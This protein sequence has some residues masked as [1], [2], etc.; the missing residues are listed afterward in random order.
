[1]KHQRNVIRE[2]FIARIKRPLQ[3]FDE[4]SVLTHGR[5]GGF[6]NILSANC[7]PAAKSSQHSQT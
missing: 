3:Q 2:V 7:C 6:L 5:S 4:S 1:M